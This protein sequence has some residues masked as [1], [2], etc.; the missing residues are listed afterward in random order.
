M[1]LHAAPAVSQRRQRY[2]YPTGVVPPHVPFDAVSIFPSCAVPLIAGGAVGLGETPATE[3]VDAE[4]ADAEPPVL[5]A[6]TRTSSFAPRS[7]WATT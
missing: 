6:V 1:S 5:E 2:A 4:V 7:P 3:A